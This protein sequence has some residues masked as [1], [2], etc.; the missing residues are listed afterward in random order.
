MVSLLLCQVEFVLMG[1]CG[2]AV[3]P[4]HWL[5]GLKGALPPSL[6]SKETFPKVYTWIDHFSE[7]VLTAKSSAPRP[8][9]LT[10]AEASEYV[11]QAEFAESEGEV[12]ANDPLGLKKGQDVESW[13][14]D[15]GFNH[16][17]R[18]RLVSLTSKEVVLASPT[19]VGGKEVRIHQPRW[20]Y[21]IRAVSG[22]GAKL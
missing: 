16:H 22:G 10:G 15:S 7:A 11:I 14:I 19:K 2:L 18:G 12:D 3:W 6:I 13:P 8:T 17:D 5:L 9:T 4:F 1:A 20:N 21:R